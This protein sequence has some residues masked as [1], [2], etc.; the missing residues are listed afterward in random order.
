MDGE[1]EERVI[2]FI[3]K[4]MLLISSLSSNELET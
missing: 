3:G 2:K 1:A 4:T